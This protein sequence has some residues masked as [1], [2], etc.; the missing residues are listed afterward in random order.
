MSRRVPDRPRF[1][2]RSDAAARH[3]WLKKRER[4]LRRRF[5]RKLRKKGASKA[6]VALIK[7][8]LKRGDL[9]LG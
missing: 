3:E 5:L 8:L 7:K 6:T 9:E 4:R 1:V 2:N